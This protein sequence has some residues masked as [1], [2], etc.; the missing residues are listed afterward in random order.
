MHRLAAILALFAV[1]LNS[2]VMCRCTGGTHAEQAETLPA[3][4]SEHHTALMV[5][6]V[7]KVVT[8]LAGG[9]EQPPCDPQDPDEQGQEQATHPS[10]AT[11]ELVTA[12]PIDAADQGLPDWSL[13]LIACGFIEYEPTLSPI[14]LLGRGDS[15]PWAA[16]TDSGFTEPELL[17]TVRIL[18]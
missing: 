2:A 17:A 7:N 5:F 8:S 4:E 11:L 10:P 12:R 9:H 14:R 18:V 16:W 15:P 1:L 13:W 3:G 6:D